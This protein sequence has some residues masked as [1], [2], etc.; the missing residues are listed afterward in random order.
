MGL[1]FENFPI[2]RPLAPKTSY[3]AFLNAQIELSDQA[4]DR[5]IAQV[6]ARLSDRAFLVLP[7]GTKLQLKQWQLPEHKILRN[8]LV[9]SL[10]LLNLPQTTNAHIDP[11][12]VTSTVQSK[13]PISRAQ[14]QLPAAM[15]P[16]LVVFKADQFWLTDQIPSAIIELN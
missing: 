5:Q 3:S 7:S 15:N 1:L 12:N 2:Q 8:A 11:M 6:S 13:Q 10:I 16:I 4:F 14:L 9:S